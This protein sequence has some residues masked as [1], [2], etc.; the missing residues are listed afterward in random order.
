MTR[1][2]E[3]GGTTSVSHALVCVFL[4][5]VG[6]KIFIASVRLTLIL[7]QNETAGRHQNADLQ[8][9]HMVGALLAVGAGNLSPDVIADKL[10]L[11]KTQLPGMLCATVLCIMSWP[12]PTM[13]T[14]AHHAVT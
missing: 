2:D 1:Q 11:G 4:S 9:R 8:V 7:I 13:S 12:S 3:S 5:Y 6:V 10:A 14:V